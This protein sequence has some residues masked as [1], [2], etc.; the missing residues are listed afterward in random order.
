VAGA[1]SGHGRSGHEAVMHPAVHAVTR[2]RQ[3]NTRHMELSTRNQT[4]IAWDAN[5]SATFPFL[6][7]DPQAGTAP[8]VQV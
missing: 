6:A 4:K 3:G 7:F 5:T 8:R 1:H 2:A